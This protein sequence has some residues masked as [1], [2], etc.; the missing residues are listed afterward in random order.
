MPNTAAVCSTPSRR[1]TFEVD[2]EEVSARLSSFVLQAICLRRIAP[3]ERFG[4]LFDAQGSRLTCY[5]VALV[6]ARASQSLRAPPLGL[7]SST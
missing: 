1:H 2:E 3:Y 4:K 6:V 5:L 7:Q